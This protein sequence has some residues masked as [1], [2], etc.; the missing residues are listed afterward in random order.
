[1][2]VFDRDITRKMIAKSPGRT[3]KHWIGGQWID[4]EKHGTSINPCTNEP[5]GLYADGG[6]KEAQQA[7]KA[8]S[9]AFSETLWKSDHALRS[10]V[11]LTIADT[12]EANSEALVKMLCTEV[13][14]IDG[15]A[16]MEVFA[17]PAILRYWAGKT[18]ITGRAGEASPG[19]H[20]VVIREAVGV[21]G[22]IAPFNAPVALT[23]RSLAPALAAG[24]TVVVKLPG[25]TAQTNELL[26]KIISETPGLSPGVI[27]LITESGS[28]GAKFLVQSPDVPAISFTGSTHTGRAI[29][30]DGAAS[31][32]RVVLELGGKTPMIV[33]DDANIEAAIPTIIKAITLFSGQFCMTGS[34]ILVQRN[35]ADSMRNRLTELLSDIKAGPSTEADSD[36][37]AMINKMNV[38]RVNKMVEEAIAAG[39]KILVRGGPV[40]EG[41]LSQGAYY[42]PTLLEITDSKLPIAQQE[43]FGP[44]ATLQVFDT[45]TEAI[46]L[47]NDSEYGLAASIWS[48]DIGRPWRVAKALQAGTVWLNTYAQIF[49][50]FEEGGYKRS[51]MGRLNGETALDNFLQYKHI[52]LNAGQTY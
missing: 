9:K 5:I 38:Q 29:A 16:A 15:E 48:Q 13:G 1:M 39:A 24:A 12:I 46:A 3:A 35:I 33:F 23:I 52:I 44:V 34:R 30:A 27:N 31:L 14:K 50:Q 37:G 41:R 20:S 42:L 26:S 25:T 19:F 17:A 28:E 21:V 32:K 22:V 43:V 40:T 49:A 11:L 7:V 8:A 51:G 10:K 2:E 4:S 36:L 45:E 6:L 47:A 18:F